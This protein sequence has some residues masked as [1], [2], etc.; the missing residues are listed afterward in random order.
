[1]DTAIYFSLSFVYFLL[2][3]VGIYAAIK[4]DWSLFSIFLLIVIAALF[5]DNSIL[6]VGRHIGEGKLLETLNA[7]RYWM[8]ALFTPLLIPF[9]LQTIRSAGVPWAKKSFTAIVVIVVTALII[10]MEVIP[11][12]DL[13]LQ[14]RWLHGVLSYKRVSTSGGPLMMLTV[15]LAIFYTSILLWRKQR[16]K[17]LF[18]GLVMMGAVGLLSIPFESKAIGNVSELMLILSLFATQL[19]QSRNENGL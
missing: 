19:F 4:A 13:T 14:P 2:L 18:V 17:W 7:P 10:I 3:I 1:M 9:C 16:G 6:A 11:L 5:Y 15:T 12:F 8:H